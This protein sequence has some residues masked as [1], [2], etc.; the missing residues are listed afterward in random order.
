[1]YGKA[2]K[3]NRKYKDKLRNKVQEERQQDFC[4]SPSQTGK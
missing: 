1:M 3:I 4:L 2:Y